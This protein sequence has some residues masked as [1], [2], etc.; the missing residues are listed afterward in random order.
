VAPPIDFETVGAIPPPPLAP[1][2]PFPAIDVHDRV[3]NSALAGHQLSDE[4]RAQLIQSQARGGGEGGGGGGEGEGR[5]GNAAG[6]RQE[7]GAGGRE[8]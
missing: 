4:E 5:R 8:G 1:P 7:V 6:R 2:P 3:L